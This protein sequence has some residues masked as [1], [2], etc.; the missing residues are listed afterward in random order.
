MEIKQ[1]ADRIINTID[2][3]CVRPRSKD[4]ERM[5]AIAMT[6]F[7]EEFTPYHHL[8][9]FKTEQQ[10]IEYETIN[11]IREKFY[12]L[13]KEFTNRAASDGNSR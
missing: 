10:K 6:I 3:V 13:S 1:L 4:I 12:T 5:L 7:A 8:D 11:S 9:D 2:G